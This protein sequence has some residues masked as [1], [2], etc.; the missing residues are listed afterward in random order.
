MTKID[1]L[2]LF[3]EVDS[4]LI[5]ALKGCSE[6]DWLR[7]TL[8]RSWRVRDVAAH[9]LDGY[10][11]T[12]SLYRDGYSQPPDRPIASWSDLVGFLNDLNGSFVS[13]AGRFSPSLLLSAL[14]WAGPI[15]T[16][17]LATLPPEAPAVYSVA[18]AGQHTSPNWFHIAREYTERVHHQLQI[19]EA[20]GTTGPLMERRLYHPFIHTLLFGLP[21]AYASVAA[22]EGTA[23]SIRIAGAGGGDWHLLKKGEAWML[24][25]GTAAAPAAGL[26]I[27][28]SAAWKLLTKGLKGEEREAQVEI[29]GQREL[30]LPALRAVSVMA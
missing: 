12:I 13:V 8:A 20:L 11:R 9:L 1:T 19:R 14:E 25:E 2:P 26:N 5:D 21:P 28:D 29:T 23:V 17:Q 6:K 30:A 22:G 3:G 7:P 15:S 24:Q 27:G 16:A 4:L 18:W 10:L